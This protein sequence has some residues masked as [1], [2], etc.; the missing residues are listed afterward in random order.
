VNQIATE[1]AEV[2][3]SK[4]R[5]L[6]CETR[7]FVAKNRMY[8]R[9]LIHSWN[10]HVSLCRPMGSSGP[11][12]GS[13]LSP[14]LLPGYSVC[15]KQWRTHCSRVCHRFLH[16]EYPGK[17]SGDG[18]KKYGSYLTTRNHRSV[19]VGDSNTLVLSSS[20]CS[21]PPG[22]KKRR[23]SPKRTGTMPIW[24]SSTSPARRHC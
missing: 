8:M 7:L 3:T 6:S 4:K 11:R 2:I 5:S 1:S 9:H 15:K 14:F 10:L 13:I 20:I 24:I 17:R 18:V 12:D 23:P 16:T 22:S 19:L 21:L